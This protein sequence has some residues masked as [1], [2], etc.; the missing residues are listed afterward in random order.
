MRRKKRTRRRLKRRRELRGKRRCPLE[1]GGPGPEGFPGIR[2]GMG[3]RAE[4]RRDHHHHP[5]S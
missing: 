4:R 2:S 3:G 1:A 5:E